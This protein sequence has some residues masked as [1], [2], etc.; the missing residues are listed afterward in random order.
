MAHHSITG[1]I[2]GGPLHRVTSLQWTIS[3]FERTGGKRKNWLSDKTFVEQRDTRKVAKFVDDTTTYA[4]RDSKVC[5]PKSGKFVKQRAC[6][7]D[8]NAIFSLFSTPL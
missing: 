2:T 7:R 1:L 3:F 4:R 6:D 8:N 5:R